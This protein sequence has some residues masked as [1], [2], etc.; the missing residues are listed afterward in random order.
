MGR[1][2]PALG[3]RMKG[4]DISRA[5]ANDARALAELHLACSVMLPDRLEN[6]LGLGYLATYYKIY[7]SEPENII[8][9]L[10]SENGSLSGLVSGVTSY[11]AHLQYMQQKKNRLLLAAFPAILRQPASA[12]RI[13]RLQ[14][15]PWI[16]GSDDLI[17]SSA[18]ITFWCWRPGAQPPGGGVILLQSWLQAVRSRGVRRVYGDIDDRNPRVTAIHR[19][20]GARIQI[21]EFP[22]GSRQ[23]LVLYELS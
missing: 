21:Q 20:L 4:L 7:L 17:S 18:H 19:Y 13:L 14:H 22:D 6:Q 5:E 1:N 9:C 16:A 11:A 2:F 3:S 12:T 23:N 8:L 15:Q 10:S